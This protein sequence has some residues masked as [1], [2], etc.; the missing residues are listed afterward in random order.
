VCARS[1]RARQRGDLL[2]LVEVEHHGVRLASLRRGSGDVGLDAVLL[3][4]ADRV[5]EDRAHQLAVDVDRALGDRLLVEASE[6]ALDLRRGDRR[7]RLA[8]ELGEHAAAGFAPPA[9]ARGLGRGPE[10]V[11]V[12]AE[13]RGLGA[14]DVLDVVQP[15]GG[16]LVEGDR[17]GLRSGGELRLALVDEAAH[18]D[19]R[20]LLVE[21]PVGHAPAAPAPVAGAVAVEPGGPTRRLIWR[22]R[23]SRHLAS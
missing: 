5:P 13:R 23:E 12:A 4:P 16:D 3:G 7:D 11:A 22:P 19:D 18:L 20:G 2:G 14:V 6:P 10:H 17:A 8:A 1:R 9:L 21:A 15:V